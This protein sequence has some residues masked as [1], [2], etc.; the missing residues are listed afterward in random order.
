VQVKLTPGNLKK[1][2]AAKTAV[3]LFMHSPQTTAQEKELLKCVT[4]TE[5]AQQMVG[6]VKIQ[7]PGIL[8][9]FPP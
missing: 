7:T 3:N 6:N 2:K 9:A 1:G 4:D 8:N 5:I